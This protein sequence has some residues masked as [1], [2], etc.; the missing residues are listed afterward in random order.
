[1]DNFQASRQAADAASLGVRTWH[2]IFQQVLQ[3]SEEETRRRAFAQQLQE[4]ETQRRPRTQQDCEQ[5]RR[6]RA[7][8][9]QAPEQEGQRRPQTQQNREAE[10]LSGR[11]LQQDCEGESSSG[12]HL[13][14]DC[15]EEGQGRKR[16]QQDCNEGGPTTTR[17]EQRPKRR[18]TKQVEDLG[19]QSLHEALTYLKADFTEKET[20]SRNNNWCK[21]I[22]HDR[23]V[24]T[25]QQFYKTFHDSKTMPLSTCAICY[26]KFAELELKPVRWEEWRD[27]VRPPQRPSQFDCPMCFHPEKEVSACQRCIKGKDN[28]GLTPAARMHAA[29]LCEHRFPDELKDLSPVEEKLIALNSC[30]GFFTKYHRPDGKRQTATYPKHLK[31]NITVFPNNVQD[32]ATRVLPHPLLKV[33]EE[34]HVSWEGTQKPERKDLS[35]L[36]SVRRDVVETALKWLKLNNPLYA[37]V[38]IDVAEMD[39][40]GRPQSGVPDQIYS[41]LTRDEPSAF[42][43]TRTA[44]IVPQTDR[45]LEDEAP[46]DIEELLANLNSQQDLDTDNSELDN[47]RDFSSHDDDMENGQEVASYDDDRENSQH[48]RFREI[49]AASRQN[50]DLHDNQ[51]ETDG[52]T[53]SHDKAMGLEKSQTA[54]GNA[55]LVQEIS[56]SGMFPLDKPPGA[57]KAD[58]LGYLYEAINTDSSSTSMPTDTGATSVEVRDTHPSEPYIM[59][60]RAANFA[61]SMDAQF[62]PK[63]FPTLF[64]FGRGG[65]RRTE[66][67]ISEAMDL[68]RD[69]V[70]GGT[71]SPVRNRTPSRNI[72][73][74][75]WAGLLLGRHGGRF[76]R[77][78]FFSFHIFNMDLKAK[79]RRVSMMSV[80]KKDFSTVERIIRSLDERTL[81]TAKRELED[82][83]KTTNPDVNI[84]LKSLSYFGGNHP[85]SKEHRMRSRR[86]IRSL[87]ISLGRPFIWFT[88]N[89][90]DITN[91]VKLRLAAYRLHESEQ[92]EEVLRELTSSYL[93]LR[94]A[95]LDPLSSLLFFHR[96]ISMFFKYY[97]RVGQDSIFGRVSNYFAN[98]ETNERGALHLH[99]LLWLHGNI[100]PSSSPEDEDRP[101]QQSD[102]EQ[103]VQYIDSVFTE[104]LS[105]ILFCSKAL[106]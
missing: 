21:P 33:M 5:Q 68:P 16:T 24:S 99:G 93:R 92:A 10:S 85:M 4:Q 35:H 39:T 14:Q 15:E 83:G 62:F 31:G 19:M 47:D 102:P 104:V 22:P 96:E 84:L 86:K 41:R 27:I 12:R 82:N 37:E 79:N 51:T 61:D 94:L 11:D 8:R 18:R 30:Y 17:G 63:T 26:C 73:L 52:N 2:D 77:H 66:E 64:P 98:V 28:E 43:K 32:L 3:N 70:L 23:K 40:W 72:G 55:L 101:R 46:V 6:R 74:R 36:L 91:P 45:G 25:V 78:P 29:I 42:E 20:L 71:D 53:A 7:L 54:D 57:N 59:V 58:Q 76:A 81:E 106:R 75:N 87:I 48:A 50:A 103:L 80:T 100:E 65:P 88:L 44:Q 95:I 9:Q 49:Q 67:D 90:N 34:I 1:M 56:A 60:S 13:Q 89:P 69:E 38:E 105:P 97:V